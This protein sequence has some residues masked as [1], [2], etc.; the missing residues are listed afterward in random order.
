MW[1]IQRRLMGNQ[2]ENTSTDENGDPLTFNTE[3][4]AKEEL[5]ELMQDLEDAGMDYDA[6]D[7][8]VEPIRG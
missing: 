4:E 8:K 3:E 1:E 6:S 7:F 2:W 5:Q